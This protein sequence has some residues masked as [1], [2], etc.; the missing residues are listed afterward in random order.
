MADQKLDMQAYLRYYT[1]ALEW[2]LSC[3]AHKAREVRYNVLYA[4]M[5]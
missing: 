5:Y 3:L 4:S 2:I 1:P